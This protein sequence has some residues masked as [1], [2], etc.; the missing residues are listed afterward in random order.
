MKKQ[1]YREHQKIVHTNNK[2]MAELR[3]LTFKDKHV[4]HEGDYL[5]TVPDSKIKLFKSDLEF[6]LETNNGL[7]YKILVKQLYIDYDVLPGYELKN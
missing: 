1:V 5:G 4:Y 6:A 3:K 2:L 7:Y